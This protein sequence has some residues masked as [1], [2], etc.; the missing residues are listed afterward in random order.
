MNTKYME[1]IEMPDEQR[2]Q[3]ETVIATIVGTVFEGCGVKGVEIYSNRVVI[4]TTKKLR[5]T[6]TE[7]LLLSVVLKIKIEKVNDRCYNLFF[8]P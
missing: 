5:L 2:Q 4:N 6:G 8:L 7:K 1:N 3:L